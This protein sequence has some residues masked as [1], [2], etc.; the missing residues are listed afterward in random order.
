MKP[1]F[2]S[3][4]MKKSFLFT[5]LAILLFGSSFNKLSAQANRFSYLKFGNA[6]G[7]TLLYRQLFPD[8][9]PK[10]KYPLVIFLHGSG[11]RGKDNEAQLKWGAL[12]F[13]TDQFMLQHP[14][15]VIAPQCPEGQ[16]WSN[17]KRTPNNTEIELNPNPSKPMEL[18]LGLIK[19]AI[20]KMPV[21]P[22]R[23]YIT[24]L[25]MGG[26]GVFDALSRAPE[27]FAA[28][29]PVC[30]GGDTTKVSSFSK[31]PIWMFHGAQDGAVNPQ[32]SMNMATALFKAGANPGL[33]MYP[34]VGHFSWLGAYID[35]PMIEW[36]YNQHK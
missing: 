15:I 33:T 17:F 12:Q 11:E 1:F 36:L 5:T 28:A 7:D 26:F 6:N 16:Q 10:A 18:L 24:G 25:S 27:L 29:V 34:T 35:Q 31:I 13:T 3:S 32:L 22:N 8:A 20:Q 19:Q 21:D 4:A 14:S 9:N 30:G 2:I 23:V